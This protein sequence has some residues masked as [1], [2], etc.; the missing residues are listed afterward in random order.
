[1]GAAPVAVPR[2][3]WHEEIGELVQESEGG[4]GLAALEA[5]LGH[6]HAH[7]DGPAVGEAAEP[8]RLAHAQ[9]HRRVELL[10]DPGH[11]EE[12]GGGDLPDVLG[13]GVDALREVHRGSRVQGIEDGEGPLRHVGE[14]EEGE[15]LVARARLRDEIGVADLEEDVAMAQHGAFGRSGGARGVHEDGEVLGPRD[16]HE[17]IEGA[18][19]LTVVAGAQL[20][21]GLERHHL[22]VAEV[23]EAVHVEHEDLHELGTAGPHLEDLIELLLVLRKE[24]AGAA[25][26]DDVLD[27][28]RRVGGVDAVG[29]PAAR[30]G[31]EIGVEPLRAV[32][33]HDGH[34]VARTQ[35]ESDQPE[36]DVADPFAVLAPGD[37]APDAQGLLAHGHLLPTLLHYLAKEPGQGVLPLD[38]ADRFV[39]GH[40][41]IFFRFQR[42]V[43]RMLSSLIP[44]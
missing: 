10:P 9:G 33:G 7:P 37:G 24:E 43:P 5:A 40:L 16:L 23:V 18:R 32:V 17:G 26:V 38:G 19:M 1:M 28:P 30:D 13:H 44:R 22:I 36:G 21:E 4:G 6:S 14:R 34:H 12:H 29:D 11:R 8:G 3:R 39:G 20:E 42:R 41:H 31:A 27:L 2:A 15:L 35:P 25:V